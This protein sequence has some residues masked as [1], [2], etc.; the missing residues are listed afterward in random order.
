[1]KTLSSLLKKNTEKSGIE[2]FANFSLNNNEMNSV[3]GGGGTD[4]ILFWWLDDGDE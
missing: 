4:P 2:N 1:M 3:V